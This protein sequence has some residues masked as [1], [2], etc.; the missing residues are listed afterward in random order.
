MR[1]A[2][3]AGA[4]HPVS[5]NVTIRVL[6]ADDDPAVRRDLRLRL[7]H[8]KDMTVVGEASNGAD[9]VMI[10]RTE[11]PDVVLMDLPM[12]GGSGLAAT[13]LLAGPAAKSPIPVVALTNRTAYAD[14]LEALDA[15]AVG[16]LLKSHDSSD[17]LAAVRAAARGEAFLSSRITV[18]LIRELTGRR[19]EAGEDAALD[20]LT[21]AE[22]EVASQ[23]SRGRTSN[24]DIAAALVVSV[25]TVRTHLSSALRKTGLADRTQL[26]LWAVRRGLD[27]QTAASEPKH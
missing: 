3:S 27:R 24:E 6:I 10:A 11:R 19:A 21:P 12:P 23:L 4:G 5:R 18:P 8:A 2:A 20:V 16:Y 25:N 15:G 13:R 1:E 7:S 17:L 26:A 14:V 9:A 22:V